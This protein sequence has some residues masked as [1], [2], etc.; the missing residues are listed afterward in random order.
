MAGVNLMSNPGPGNVFK[1]AGVKLPGIPHVTGCVDASKIDVR[2]GNG[3][4]GA[5]IQY[6]GADPKEFDV[7]LHLV[8]PADYDEW[9]TGQGRAILRAAPTGKNAKAFAVEHPSC[10]ECGIASAVKVSVSQGTKQDDGSYK[11]FIKLMPSAPPKP[12]SGTPKGSQFTQ[13]GGDAQSAADKTI[14]DITAQI[15]KLTS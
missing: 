13:K 3:T 9:L 8:E 10:Q 15:K 2:K 5:N 14:S 6:G 11:V 7:E 4:S 12:A 1:V